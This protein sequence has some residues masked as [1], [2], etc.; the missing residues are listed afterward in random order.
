M[1]KDFALCLNDNYIP[2]ASVVIKSIMDHM[3]KNDEVFIHILSDFISI[4][5]KHYLRQKFPNTNIL[6]Y[7]IDNKQ[8]FHSL[9]SVA[10]SWTIYAWYR[11][12]LSEVLDNSVHKVLYL[13]CDI[14]VNSDLDELFAINMDGKSIGACIDIETRTPLLYKRLE[15]DSQLQYVCSGVLL[16]NLDKWRKCNIFSQIMNYAINNPQKLVCPDQDAINY[17]CRND[18]IIL[19]PKYGVITAYFRYKW[20][21]KEHLS[22]MDELMEHPAIIHYAIYQPWLYHK[23]KSMHSTLWW[24]TFNKLKS[25]PYIRFHYLI[26]YIKYWCKILLIKLRLI[27]K[28]DKHY[29]CDLYYY[30]PKIKMTDVYKMMEEVREM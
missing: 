26:T 22:E 9:P 15:Y 19:P 7:H 17:V 20:F 2:Y 16:I 8:Y 10:L 18:K 27:K 12:L 14:I 5:H 21:I 24:K 23:N 4:K 30:H 1:R 28:G 13:D 25:F 3:H 11:I 6:L 29:I